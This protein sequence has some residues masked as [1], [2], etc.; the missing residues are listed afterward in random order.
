M[1]VATDGLPL[2]TAYA[3]AQAR[4]DT[5]RAGAGVAL[6]LLLEHL[7][8]LLGLLLRVLELLLER[9]GLLLRLLVPHTQEL[10]LATHEAD[11]LAVDDR[12]RG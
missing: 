12:E 11:N 4:T 9:L 2:S 8:E 6:L 1:H 7:A 3:C 10:V 5:H